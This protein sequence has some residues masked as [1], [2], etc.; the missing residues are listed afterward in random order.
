VSS[1]GLDQNTGY[2]CGGGTTVVQQS[3]H[4]VT[5]AVV[6]CRRGDGVATASYLC[7]LALEEVVIV[8]AA[9]KTAVV[10]VELVHHCGL[11]WEEF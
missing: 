7:P 9:E 5:V 3:H 8:I 11:F 1:C 6:R 2:G 10:D 4:A